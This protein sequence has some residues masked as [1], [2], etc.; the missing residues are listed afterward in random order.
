M[1]T[2]QL[3]HGNDWMYLIIA[4]QYVADLFENEYSINIPATLLLAKW[5]HFC[6]KKVKFLQIVLFS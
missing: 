6:T 1:N 3:K 4:L 5:G 2:V